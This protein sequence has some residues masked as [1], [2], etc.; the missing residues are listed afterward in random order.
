MKT[1]FGSE[2]VAFDIF[3]LGGGFRFVIVNTVRLK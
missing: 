1:T 2:R 3:D